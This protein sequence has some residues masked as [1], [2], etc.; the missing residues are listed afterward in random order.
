M[1]QRQNTF[2][3]ARSKIEITSSSASQRPRRVI[4]PNVYLLSSIHKVEKVIKAFATTNYSATFSNER[5]A[6]AQADSICA[7]PSATPFSIRA[8]SSGFTEM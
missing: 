6:K 5:R 4:P 3:L 8:G 7:K 2:E 1:I